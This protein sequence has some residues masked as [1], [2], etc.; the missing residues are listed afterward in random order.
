M[1]ARA[2]VSAPSCQR[3]IDRIVGLNALSAASA[4]GPH[5]ITVSDVSRIDSANAE[6]CIHRSVVLEAVKSSTIDV[7]R[8]SNNML[9]IEPVVPELPVGA[10]VALYRGLN[11]ANEACFRRYDFLTLAPSAPLGDQA[12]IDAVLNPDSH[13]DH[14][15]GLH[16]RF[17]SFS[18]HPQIAIYYA[19]HRFD[20]MMK[21]GWVAEV[22]LATTIASY[23]G[24]ERPAVWHAPDHVFLDPRGLP[25]QITER[26]VREWMA[27]RNN[28]TADH[29]LLLARGT[30]QIQKERIRLV[31]PDDWD[32]HTKPWAEWLKARS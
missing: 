3:F 9:D 15:I 28:A 12:D 10:G 4:H 24:A 6:S 20:G 1:S 22:T 2:I 29:E 21:T 18:L 23:G 27:V 30:L 13:Y 7:N 31:R 8:Y 26:G 19:T 14:V 11:G 5:R 17:V 25:P 16:R 32:R